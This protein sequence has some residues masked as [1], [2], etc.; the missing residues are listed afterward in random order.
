MSEP[1]YWQGPHTVNDRRHWTA[2]IPPI[3]AELSVT[4]YLD[5]PEAKKYRWTSLIGKKDTGWA[6]TLPKAQRAARL[7]LICRGEL[8]ASAAR[9]LVGSQ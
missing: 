1:I 2:D 6:E 8:I 7:S 9:R 5:L 4:E 3:R